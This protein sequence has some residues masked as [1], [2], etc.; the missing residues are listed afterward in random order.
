MAFLRQSRENSPAHVV[1]ELMQ[2]VKPEK[3][4]WHI[5]PGFGNRFG[6]I[7]PMPRQIAELL[8]NSPGS[9]EHLLWGIEFD[10]SLSTHNMGWLSTGVAAA[11]FCDLG[12]H[13]RAG[14]GI[15]QLL[16]APGLLAHALELANKPITAMPF[17]DEEHYVIDPAAKK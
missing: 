9:G 5:A 16:C 13:P 8:H 15:Y 12:F 4:D 10:N 1:A 11:V 7:D 6:A 14:A 2:G 17:L 3:G